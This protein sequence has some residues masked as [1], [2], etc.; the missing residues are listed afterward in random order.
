[1][2]GKGI[3]YTI[4]KHLA[5]TVTIYNRIWNLATKESRSDRVRY[6]LK[7]KDVALSD[8]VA[9]LREE[10]EIESSS[11]S[12]IAA[13]AASTKVQKWSNEELDLKYSHTSQSERGRHIGHNQSYQHPQ[14]PPS[15]QKSFDSSFEYPS[16]SKTNRNSTFISP[17]ISPI[18]SFSSLSPLLDSCS[19][20]RSPLPHQYH[21]SSLVYPLFPS[22]L[23]SSRQSSSMHST[24]TEYDASGD[25]EDH[26][27]Q[28]QLATADL[29]YYDTN[30]RVNYDPGNK[31]I[32]SP[33]THISD[34]DESFF[35]SSKETGVSTSA[36]SFECCHFYDS[37]P[38]RC[39]LVR[40]EELSDTKTPSDL[41]EIRYLVFDTP[42]LSP[43]DPGQHTSQ[44]HEEDFEYFINFHSSS[45]SANNS[46]HSPS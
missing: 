43:I 12:S 41:T 44:G 21:S 11:S 2:N 37:S 10:A 24:L 18:R 22:Q 5:L 7:E 46:E 20:P 6:I 30:N 29:S 19:P 35:H 28:Q 32:L 17:I 39:S 36:S 23:H 8:L 4:S 38:T 15:Y 33:K 45:M 42:N 9:A 1:M 25:V 26:H 34:I 14:C 3:Y 31:Y 16:Y 40:T 27:H 13:P